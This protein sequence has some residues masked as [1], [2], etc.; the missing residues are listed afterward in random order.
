VVIL[1]AI[2]KLEDDEELLVIQSE[3]ARLIA[4]RSAAA[5]LEL[6]IENDVPIMRFYSLRPPPGNPTKSLPSDQGN[7]CRAPPFVH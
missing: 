4:S 2:E 5:A 7:C 3:V 6:A 1:E